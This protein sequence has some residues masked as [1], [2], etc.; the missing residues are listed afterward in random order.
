M[1][2][3]RPLR[4]DDADD[5]QDQ[6]AVAHLQHRRRQL[7]DR[8][9]LLAHDFLALLD[10]G[11]R[12]DRE[13]LV[14]DRLVDVQ[15]RGEAGHVAL[16][17]LEETSTVNVAQSQQAADD[18]LRRHAAQDA[19]FRHAGSIAFRAGVFA[20]VQA[21]DAGFVDVD[22]LRFRLFR[23]QAGEQA[24]G[25]HLLHPLAAQRRPFLAQVCNQLAQQ[26]LFGRCAGRGKSFLAA[27][28]HSYVMY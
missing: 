8:L 23:R 19:A 2:C 6:H 10:E 14:G 4:V 16:I 22:G 11:E 20:G 18:L 15:R 25:G 27:L 9:L 13:D 17:A 12:D 24:F 26:S 3:L 1:S 5:R 21:A 28:L 7:A